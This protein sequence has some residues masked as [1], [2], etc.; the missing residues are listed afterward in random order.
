VPKV[1][2]TA[3]SIKYLPGP[4]LDL[5]RQAD[6]EALDPPAGGRSLNE[7][8]LIA[9]LAGV[10]GVVAGQDEFTE[11]V[12]A[13]HP[14]LKVV[15]RA[16]VG[17][18]K[19][20]VEAATRHG[21]WVTITP[22]ANNETVADLAMAL[23][24]AV[25]RQV[26]E[27]VTA[28]RA[29]RWERK[30]GVDVFAKTLGIL[31]FGRIGKSLARRARGFSMRILAYDVVWDE[32][33]AQ[34]LG[35][36]RAEADE[37]FRQA[38]FISLHLPATPQTRH[39]VNASTL[40][41]MKPTAYLVNT[42]RGDLIDEPALL[43]ALDEGIIAGAGLDVFEVEPPSSDH[44]LL[45][46]PKVLPMPHVA[47]IT[48]ESMQAMAIMSVECVVAALQGKRPPY[49]VNEPLPKGSR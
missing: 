19:I 28:T 36:I 3:R 45:H 23:I 38:D 11:K 31:G 7:E 29:G 1:L 40:R 34:E 37:I 10:E 32:T 9:A 49:P 21:V 16:G 47:G 27:N 44:P 14:Q 25:A 8:Q 17:Y 41:L 24:L 12:F 22:G 35:V 39:I 26:V 20:D 13:A 5:L 15:A 4:H 48:K 18:D 43:K 30:A 42:A 6:V 46:H 33:A 2:F